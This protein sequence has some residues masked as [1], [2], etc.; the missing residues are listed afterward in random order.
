MNEFVKN[1]REASDESADESADEII[2]QIKASHKVS[3]VIGW[4]GHEDIKVE[5]RLLNMSECR[6]AK[7][8]NQLEFKK[9][10]IELSVANLADYREQEVVHGLWRACYNPA[11]GE[12]IFRNAEDLRKSCTPDELLYLSG[13]FNGFVEEQDPNI[14]K[15]SDE[16]FESL[17]ELLK[18]TPD[19]IQL[20]VTNLP[21]AWKLLHTLVAQQPK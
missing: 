15:L 11:T 4:P 19:Q 12:R 17:K 8:D 14:N 2:E 6:Q 7:I 13:E 5:M 3:R 21:L 1:I 9:A 18:K 20:K 16:D 10:G